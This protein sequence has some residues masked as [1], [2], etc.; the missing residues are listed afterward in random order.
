GD[1]GK[2]EEQDVSEKDDWK[3]EY[4]DLTKYDEDGTEILYT[5][6]EIEV[7]GY[8][9][10]VEGH[11]I[12][13]LRV[14]ETA[15]SGEKTWIEEDDQYRP[16]SITVQLLAHG[17]EE[18]TKEVSEETDWKYNFTDLPKYDEEGKEINYT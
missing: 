17:E 7:D 11:N 12:T 5:I 14:G 6:D 2:T 13:N 10:K 1:N 16:E 18:T 8:E 4:K 15:V 3:Y 9:T